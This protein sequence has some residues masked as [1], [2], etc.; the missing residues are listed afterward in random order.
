MA[1]KSLDP[2]FLSL[3]DGEVEESQQWARENSPFNHG[4]HLHLIHP[5]VRAEWERIL[6]KERRIEIVET[7]SQNG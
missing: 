5:V 7:T 2:A 4:H 6:D 3:T 1:Y